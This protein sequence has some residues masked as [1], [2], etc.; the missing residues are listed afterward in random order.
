MGSIATYT[1]EPTKFHLFAR[2]TPQALAFFF[3]IFKD[4]GSWKNSYKILSIFAKFPRVVK[5]GYLL[6]AIKTVNSY[7]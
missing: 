6:E 7:M 4:Y 2:Q 3:L 1:C 5:Q